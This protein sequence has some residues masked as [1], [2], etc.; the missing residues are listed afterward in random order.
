MV[1]VKQGCPTGD[2]RAICWGEAAY[3][4]V[5]LKGTIKIILDSN[6]N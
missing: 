3:I 4:Y 1:C 5:A 2:P 6:M